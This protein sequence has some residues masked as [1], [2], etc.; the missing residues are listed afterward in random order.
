MHSP[1][2]GSRRQTNLRGRARHEGTTSASGRTTRIIPPRLTPAR[3]K[4]ARTR[5]AQPQSASNASHARTRS[6]PELSRRHGVRKAPETNLP[7]G[8]D[9]IIGIEVQRLTCHTSAPF[10][11]QPPGLVSGRLCPGTRRRSRDRSPG[12]PAAFRLPAFAS[13]ASCS[14]QRDSALLTVGLP[15]SAWTLAGFPRCAHL[16]HDRI[17]CPLYPEAQRCSH[18]RSDPSGRRSPPLPG[19]RPYHP[20]VHSIF[21]SCLL[22]GV[23]EG[24]LAFTRPVFP[25]AC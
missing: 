4:P 10:P 25:L 21:R 17:G 20:G 6:V 16:S 19:A 9:S 8:S 11:G 13:W 22:R 2:E 23:I 5:P 18:G 3:R 7:F 14:R 12:F 1:Q 24:S 15:G